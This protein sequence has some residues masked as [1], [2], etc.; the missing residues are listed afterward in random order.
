MKYHP[1]CAVVAQLLGCT[2]AQAQAQYARNA[3]AL[4]R[5][6]EKARSMAPRKYRGYT[7]DQWQASADQF[8]EYARVQA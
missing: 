8:A 2:E 1:Q 3:A 4:Q 7:A 5:D 6:A